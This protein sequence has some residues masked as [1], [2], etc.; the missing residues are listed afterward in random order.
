[1]YVRECVRIC[2]C[3]GAWACACA[4]AHVALLIQQATNMC[5]IVFSR[6]FDI[7]AY[8]AQFSGKKKLL[9]KN[10]CSD[11][12]DNF[13]SKTILILGTIQRD[14]ATNVKKSPCEV[15]VILV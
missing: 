14:I 15:P 11:F 10:V 3:P 5:Y 4:R 13:F 12:I 6:F 9:N 2:G 1:V 7:T 8:K